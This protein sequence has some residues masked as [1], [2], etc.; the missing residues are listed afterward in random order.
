MNLGCDRVKLQIS[1]KFTE[2]HI[3]AGKYSDSQSQIRFLS[4]VAGHTYVVK[5]MIDKYFP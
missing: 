2:A 5:K 3:Y 4:D 1:S